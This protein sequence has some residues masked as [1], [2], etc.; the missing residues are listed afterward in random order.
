[1]G[2]G[3]ALKEWVQNWAQDML[4]HFFQNVDVSTIDLATGHVELTDLSLRPSPL[5]SSG[6][7]LSSGTVQRIVIN[8]SLFS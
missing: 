2:L 8:A 5:P 1:M 3:N 4:L 6:L 7:V